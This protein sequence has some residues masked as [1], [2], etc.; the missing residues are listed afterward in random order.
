MGIVLPREKSMVESVPWRGLTQS[1]SGLAWDAEAGPA[2]LAGEAWGFAEASAPRSRVETRA[3]ALPS[4]KKL[5]LLALMPFGIF[6][7]P[8]ILR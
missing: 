4:F 3:T 2:G 7:P 6:I 1:A 8:E 5:R